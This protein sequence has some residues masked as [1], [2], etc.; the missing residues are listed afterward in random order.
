VKSLQTKLTVIILVIF[1]ASLG[2]LGGLNYWKAREIISGDLTESLTQNAEN[3]AGDIGDWLEARKAE[4]TIMSVA[5]AVQSGNIE[6]LVPFLSNAVK[7][8]KLYYAIGFAL[9]S[10]Q[11][12]N[13]AGL[14]LDLSDR[15][16]FKQAMRGE[17]PVSDPLVSKSTGHLVTVIAIPVKVDGKVTGILY[18]TVD[19]AG[20]SKKVLEIKAGQT[21]YALVAQGD[22]LTIIHPDKEVAM[23][24]NPLKDTNADSG[25]KQI[26]EQ[27]VKG[28]KG[29]VQLTVKGIDRYYAYAPVPGMNWSLAV[30]VPVKEVTGKLSTLT[31][32]SLSTIVVVL[33]LAALAISFFARRIVKPI[34]DL[35][36]AADRIA[37]GDISIGK[38]G[39]TSN[40]E[41]GR[42]GLAF[43][44]MTLNLRALIKKVSASTD[45]VA[46]SSEELTASA[47]QSAQAANQV[48]IAISEVATGAEKQLKAVDD[49]ASVVGQMSTGVKQIAANVNTAAGT[50]AKSA[51]AAQEGS[52]AV[53]KAVTQMGQIEQTVTRSAQVVSKLGERSKEIGA[54]VDTISGIAG[55]T[56]LLALN[57]AIEAAR[58]GE[59]GRGFAVVAEE[60]R[61]LAEQSQDAA[62]Q[63]AGLIGE[64]RQDTDSAV[65]AMN[66]GTKEVRIGAEVVNDAGEAF[67]EIYGSI[68]E[69]SIQMQEISAAIQQL[70]SGSQQ[71]VSSVREIDVISKEAV[72]Q[73]QMVSAATEEQSAT[74][75]EIA[76]SSQALAKMAEEL[77][78]V[79]S[80]FKV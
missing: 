5:P 36:A 52:K 3:S 71:I 40:D 58:A 39:I 8:N 35:E 29:I 7:V 10:G 27:M 25:Q 48:A 74:M 32:I 6:A 61:K 42:L 18:G 62:K 49:T 33:V 34:R 20:I 1:L 66:E 38:L 54:I 17:T 64:I 30:A 50:S 23:K 51:V 65:M 16:Y 12:H 45:Q 19:M 53:G 55:Q 24:A 11:A 46:A 72:S 15:E 63:I 73:S 2:T 26:T 67:R 21:G 41:I 75:E 9:P 31:V 28:E 57:A 80:T 44:K 76:A 59:Q 37:D 14:I 68:N 47:E 60:V 13:S 70:A 43:E 77:T 4:L 79:V 56:N 78:Q 69:V 22:G